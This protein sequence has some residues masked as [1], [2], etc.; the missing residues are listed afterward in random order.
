MI[1]PF[2]DDL[3]P[4]EAGD[5]YQYYDADQHRWIVEF[6]QVDYYGGP[7]DL[8]TF[9]VILLDPS[10]YPTPT[11]DGEIIVQYLNGMEQT[12]NTFGIENY[13]ETVG[14]Q[15]HFNGT[16]H[17]WAVPVTDSFAIKYTTYPPDY[18]GIEEH[19]YLT[20]LPSVTMLT[21]VYPNPGKH[22]MK[23]NYQIAQCSNIS[24]RIYDAA[25][26]LVRIVAAKDECDP[27]YYS[28]VWNTKDDR[29][30]MV[31]AGVHFIQLETD[32]YQR[33]ENAIILR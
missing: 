26:R 27:G 21:A 12:G 15:Y 9:Q 13:A 24:L 10:Y 6:Y 4:S 16:Y 29:G 18:T 25:G 1:A 14:I 20:A 11:N 30:R 31:P 22:A 2:W 5:I 28:D 32:K 19:E 3:D 7:G 8:E 17:E 33:V 23:I